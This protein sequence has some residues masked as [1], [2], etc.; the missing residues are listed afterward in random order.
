VDGAN[1]IVELGV[2][3]DAVVVELIDLI[4][5]ELTGGVDLIL[6]STTL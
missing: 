1:D 6:R 3:G 4:T 5:E 2:G